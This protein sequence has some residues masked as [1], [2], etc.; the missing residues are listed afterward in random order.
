MGKD[1]EGSGLG[2][3]EVLSRYLPGE[4]RESQRYC[5]VF[6][7]CVMNNSGFWI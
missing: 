6:G 5:H 2:L 7:V 4:T 3:L 1:L